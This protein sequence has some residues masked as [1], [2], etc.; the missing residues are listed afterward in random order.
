MK[1]AVIF[2]MDGVLIDSNDAIWKAQNEVLKRHGIE[3]GPTEIRGYLGKSLRDNLEE[4]NR[5]YNLSIDIESHTKETW[6]IELKIL[7]KMRPDQN[8][9]KLLNILRK[10]NVAMAVGT[11][12]DNFI[13][14][15]ILK[16]LNIKDYF[17]AIVTSSDVP[18]HKPNPDIFLEAARRLKTEPKEC[19]VFEDASNGI[20]AARR[21]GM[22]CIARLHNYNLR[23]ELEDADLII[24]D[25]SEVSYD[26]I[27]EIYSNKYL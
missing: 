17:Q 18:N 21:A 9:I 1:F 12:S 23:Q 16:I 10:N 22:K 4:W 19:I 3:L 5:K 24:G 2:D 7:E 25:F 26:L 15:K 13:A 20:E 8:L 6:A 27:K 11:S 14:E